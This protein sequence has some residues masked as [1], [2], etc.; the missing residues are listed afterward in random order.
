MKP[1]KS[2]DNLAFD[3]ELAL[4]ARE[5]VAVEGFLAMRAGMPATT[6]RISV[7]LKEAQTLKRAIA[8]LKGG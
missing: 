3:L 1:M 6:D 7:A 5:Q 2:L 8:V 4:N